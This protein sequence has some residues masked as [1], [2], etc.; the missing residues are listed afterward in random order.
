VLDDDDGRFPKLLRQL[1][2]GI[3]VDEVI[4]TQLLALQLRCAGNAPAGAVGV[5]R[6]ALVRILAVA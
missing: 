2:A 6:G 4:E 1:P 3:Q 5:E